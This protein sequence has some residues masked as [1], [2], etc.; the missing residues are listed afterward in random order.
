MIL[1]SQLLDSIN[2]N[3]LVE[4]R[5]KQG[6]SQV[7]TIQEPCDKE[8]LKKILTKEGARSIVK[9]VYSDIIEERVSHKGDLT[10]YTVI[11]VDNSAEPCLMTL[12]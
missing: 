4:L 7:S 6:G 5:L 12:V 10:T 9:D 3:E 8:Y 11:T 1:L 2:P